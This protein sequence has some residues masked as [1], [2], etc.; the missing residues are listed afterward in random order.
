MN[1]QWYDEPSG[2]WGNSSVSFTVPGV[3]NDGTQRYVSATSTGRLARFRPI[4]DAAGVYTVEAAFPDSSNSIEARYTVNDLDGAHTFDI[5][6]N[7]TGGQTNQWISLGEFRFS[8]ESS[9]GFG[10]H[11]ITVGNPSTTGNRIY[12]GA[13]RLDYVEGLNAAAC[14]WTC[15]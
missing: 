1:N 10:V 9:G 12:S 15:Y 7:S 2:T 4:F 11:S 3:T 5:N 14:N 13:V 6:Q 8:A